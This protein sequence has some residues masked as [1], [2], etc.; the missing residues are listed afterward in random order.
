M[1]G[2]SGAMDGM[3]IFFLENMA[4]ILVRNDHGMIMVRTFF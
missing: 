4:K 2:R 3:W 1:V